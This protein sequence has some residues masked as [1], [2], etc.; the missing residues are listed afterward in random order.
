MEQ[1]TIIK[2]E[3]CSVRIELGIQRITEALQHAGYTVAEAKM[4]ENFEDYRN[5]SG[6]KLYAGVQKQDGFLQWLEEN[7][8]LVFHTREPEEEGFYIESCPARLTVISGGSETGALYGCMELKERVERMGEMPTEITFGDAPVFKLRGPAVGLQKT[9]VEAPRLTYEY[10]ITPE[11]FPWF[12][13]RDMWTKFMDMLLDMRCNVLYIWSGHPFSSLVKVPDYPEAL[14]VTEEEFQKNRELFGWLTK[15]CDRRGI[16]VVLKFYN[17]HIPLPF[18]RA[19]GL[20]LLQSNI[21]PLV[22]DYTRQSI[23]EFIKSFPHIGLMVCL[24]EALRGTQN[25]TDWFMDTIIP[26]VKD[27]VKEAGLTEK[28]PII[29]RGHDCDPIGAME[30]AKKKYTNLYTMWKYNGESLTT[31]YPKGNWQKIHQSLSGLGTTH[32]MNI[33][34]LADLEPFQF[35]APLYIQKCVQAGQ[36]RYGCNG[37]HLYPL[38]YWD[39]PYTPD[40]VSPRLLQMNRDYIWFAAWFRYAWNPDR[41]ENTEREHWENVFARHYGISREMAEKLLTAQENLAQCAPKLLGRVGITEGNRQTLSLGM[42]MSQFTNVTRFRPNRELWESVARK[43]EQPDDYMIKEIN[44]E[45]HLGETPYDCVEEVIAHAEKALDLCREVAAAQ[46]EDREDLNRLYTDARAVYSMT[47][48]YCRKIEAAMEILRYKYT[49][50]EK[51]RGDI[52]LLEKAEQKM[53]ESLEEYKKLASLTEETYLYANSMQTPQRKIPFP[54]GETYGHWTACLPEYQK[55]LE[56]FRTHL[57][58]LQQGILPIDHA[59]EVTAE[60]LKPAPYTLLGSESCETYE[61]KKGESVFSD[62]S[63]KII[64]LAPEL[65]NLTG[66]RMGLGAAI[67]EG[68]TVKLALP[69][70]SYVLVGYM[71]AKGVEWLQLPD[72]E[73]NTHADDRGGLTVVYA[74]AM[75]AEACPPIKIHAYRYEK[76]THE[77]YFGTGAFLIAGVIASDTLMK[78]RNAN[79]AGEGLETLDWLYE[80]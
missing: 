67:E 23:R 49:M 74:N 4:P 50:D 71:N 38:F 48:S 18:A 28:P 34:I 29:L 62:C 41:E 47:I 61:L 39:W 66:V 68:V 30:E 80:E 75:K 42:S 73:T 40:K 20:E 59:R 16:W 1:I 46:G 63:C 15:E 54:N 60:P 79:L 19:H 8:I 45:Q 13:D 14:E 27:G 69:Q 11:R 72:L 52:K 24:G 31:Y 57:A 26:G 77:I 22:A 21:S 7:E 43:G 53:S 5:I 10:P 25:K 51:C 56:H 17:I 35:N 55:E 33:H 76:G 2:N 70:D 44:K 37:L 32:I 64:N 78:P 65:T 6:K 9:K 12:Y 3:T 36:N 58:E